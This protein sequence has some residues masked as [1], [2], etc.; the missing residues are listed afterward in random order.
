MDVHEI[1]M[2]LL[3]LSAVGMSVGGLRQISVNTP[4]SLSNSPKKKIVLSAVDTP[5]D[6]ELPK[7]VK[8]AFDSLITVGLRAACAKIQLES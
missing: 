4:Q 7:L 8:A 2:A 3:I 1:P 6:L 5:A